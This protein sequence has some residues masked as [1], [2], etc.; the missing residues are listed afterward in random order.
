MRYRFQDT[1][2]NLAGFEQLSKFYSEA[3][4]LVLEDVIID[5]SSCHWF[6]ANMTAPLG[7]LLGLVANS[8]N[9]VT[10]EN[11]SSGLSNILSKNEFLQRM[12]FHCKQT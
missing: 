2:T 1:R 7:A 12:V 5:F 4:D 11:I 3:K 10:L 6:D 9:D 8:F